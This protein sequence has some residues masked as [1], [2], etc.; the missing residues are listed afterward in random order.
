VTPSV[1][2]PDDINPSDATER[3][4]VRLKADRSEVSLIVHSQVC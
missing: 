1:A 4:N 2:A 3:F